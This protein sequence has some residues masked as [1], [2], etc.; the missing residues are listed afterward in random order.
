MD[1]AL[2]MDFAT[3]LENEMS[4]RKGLKSV[5]LRASALASKK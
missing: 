1:N 2:L 3:W 5:A 4:I